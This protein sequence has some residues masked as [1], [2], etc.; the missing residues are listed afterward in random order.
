MLTR[1]ARPFVS[2]GPPAPFHYSLIPVTIA[3]VPAPNLEG[4]MGEPNTLLKGSSGTFEVHLSMYHR[5]PGF[6]L[7]PFL[8]DSVY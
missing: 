8:S 4:L 3:G 6:L 5:S 2:V 7:T 1:K